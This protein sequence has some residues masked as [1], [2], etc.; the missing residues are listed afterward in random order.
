MSLWTSHGVLSCQAT[1]R[2]LSAPSDPDFPG[3]SRKFL[4]TGFTRATAYQNSKP[5]SVESNELAQH[6]TSSVQ[7]KISQVSLPPSG[8]L[9]HLRQ[10]GSALSLAPSDQPNTSPG[11]CAAI[12]FHWKPPHNQT[13]GVE[14][15]C[16]LASFKFG[17]MLYVGLWRREKLFV[18]GHPQVSFSPGLLLLLMEYFTTVFEITCQAMVVPLCEFIFRLTKFTKIPV[19]I[20]CTACVAAPAQYFLLVLSTSCL[21]C[22]VP[23]NDCLDVGRCRPGHLIDD[24]V[25][26]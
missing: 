20:L 14:D 11:K 7:T 3:C 24:K 5:R 1:A 25:C 2:S 10:Q 23:G 19:M 13:I 26:K 4:C 12:I 16:A 21:A 22:T 15:L 17:P 8:F 18:P 6:S 9:S